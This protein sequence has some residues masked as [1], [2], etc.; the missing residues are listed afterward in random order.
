[1][2]ATAFAILAILISGPALADVAEYER[3]AEWPGEPVLT[4]D[5]MV[6][7]EH[8]HLGADGVEGAIV[9]KID[10]RVVHFDLPVMD[11]EEEVYRRV[12]TLNEDGDWIVVDNPSLE[13]VQLRVQYALAA[14]G[15]PSEDR[16]I[17]CAHEMAREVMEGVM[18]GLGKMLQ[19]N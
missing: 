14:H 7:S 15:G 18:N 3:Y 11:Q 8:V 16:L 19:G 17:E 9:V 4:C 13:Q 10:D 12:G 1:M 2:R 5:N 6:T